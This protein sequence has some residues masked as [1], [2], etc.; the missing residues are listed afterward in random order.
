VIVDFTSRAWWTT[1]HGVVLGTGFILTLA[2]VLMVL[3]GLREDY[4]TP[5]G[6]R[7]RLLWLRRGLITM[8]IVAWLAV[9]VGTWVIDPWYHLH[10]PGSPLE[11][12]LARPHLTFW[13]DQ[14]MEWK[15]RISWT[16][17]LLATAAAYMTVYYGDELLWNH[18]ARSLMV[19]MF[20]GAFGA[21]VAAG[22]M[23][24]LLTKVV[25]VT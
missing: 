4:L 10:Q 15:E 6:A 19:T 8:A 11:L 17:A 9:I 22:I 24:M 16:A 23:G 7:R 21:A 25:P 13:T 12:L 2:L 20:G 1:F 5:E 18:R 14:V 3:P